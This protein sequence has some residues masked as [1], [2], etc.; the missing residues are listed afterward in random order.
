MAQ[1]REM[2]RLHTCLGADGQSSATDLDRLRHPSFG[3]ALAIAMLDSEKPTQPSGSSKVGTQSG[4]SKQADAASLGPLVDTLERPRQI[5]EIVAMVLF[6]RR[7][8]T[9][10]HYVGFCSLEAAFLSA[11]HATQTRVFDATLAHQLA[12]ESCWTIVK[13]LI[14]SQ[15]DVTVSRHV[16]HG[17]G[18]NSSEVACLLHCSWDHHIARVMQWRSSAKTSQAGQAEIKFDK[19][20]GP[21][22]PKKELELPSSLALAVPSA[23]PPPYDL[24]DDGRSQLIVEVSAD[25]GRLSASCNASGGPTLSRDEP[26]RNG[27]IA[28]AGVD[29]E[30]QLPKRPFFVEIC[31]G[32]WPSSVLHEEST[33]SVQ[34]MNDPAA[35]TYFLSR[36]WGRSSPLKNIWGDSTSV[37]PVDPA[38][39]CVNADVLH[40]RVA[41]V[42]SKC[43]YTG[44]SRTEHLRTCCYLDALSAY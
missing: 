4:D 36:A 32:A 39:L 18:R 38:T 10:S 12:S 23:P 37:I 15:L 13:A 3:Q 27:K 19:V 14:E 9:L 34:V 20:A 41:R 42:I 7:R 25:S 6:N 2:M 35:A 33:F 8:F 28:V 5:F 1:I 22:A 44:Q 30:L 26:H 24:I 29:K 43:E 40:L 11:P 31:L 21:S 17:N 16:I